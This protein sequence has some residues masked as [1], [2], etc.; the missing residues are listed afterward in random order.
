MQKKYF[1]LLK[2][3]K[4]TESAQLCL[5]RVFKDYFSW[6]FDLQRHENRFLGHRMTSY[7]DLH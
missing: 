6:H 2:K 1:L 3:L 5:S 7:I 4:N